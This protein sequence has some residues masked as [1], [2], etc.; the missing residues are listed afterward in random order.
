MN[1]FWRAQCRECRIEPKSIYSSSRFHNL[2]KICRRRR[3]SSIVSH[4]YC[5]VAKL[6]ASRLQS[7]FVHP[8]QNNRSALC[9]DATS[10]SES[11]AARAACD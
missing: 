7:V 11:D 9:D 2:G 1:F 3:I 5:F 10:A 6:F 8:G 4:N